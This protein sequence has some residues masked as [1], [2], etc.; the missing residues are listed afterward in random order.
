MSEAH[1]CLSGSQRLYQSNTKIRMVLI[2]LHLTVHRTSVG[3]Y[4]MVV[5]DNREYVINELSN[6]IDSCIF[7]L[8]VQYSCRLFRG[9]PLMEEIPE[10]EDYSV[11]T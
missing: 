6:I 9:R 10:S 5:K 1:V 2:I 8:N 3:L 7:L 11:G 4:N